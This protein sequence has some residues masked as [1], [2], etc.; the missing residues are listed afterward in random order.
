M[1]LSILFSVV[2]AIT[3]MDRAREL[4]SCVVTSALKLYNSVRNT[5]LSHIT[6]LRESVMYYINRGKRVPKVEG[7][8]DSDMEI[9]PNS[10][11][12]REFLELL[13]KHFESKGAENLA[14]GAENQPEVAKDANNGT[15]NTEEQ[16]EAEPQDNEIE[17]EES[18]K[19]ENNEEKAKE[20]VN[21]VL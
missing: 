6:N 20:A 14:D 4:N 21:D 12:I 11:Q 16:R 15:E 17:D 18:V 3:L 9:D 2:A 8:N 10:T 13:A 19:D 1:K 5:A 7:T